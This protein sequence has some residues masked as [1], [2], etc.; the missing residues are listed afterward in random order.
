ML[1][2]KHI[3][4][5][6]QKLYS[7]FNSGV[8]ILDHQCHIIC[9]NNWMVKYSKLKAETVCDHSFEELFP[10]PINHRLHQAIL[11]NLKFGLPAT[12]SNILNKSPIPLYIQGANDNELL[13]QQIYITRLEVHSSDS[14]YC[15]INITDVTAA[16]LREKALENQV[17]ERKKAEQHLL[18]RTHQ[19]QSALSVSNAGVFKFDAIEKKIFLDQKASQIFEFESKYSYQDVFSQWLE[20]V[21][22]TDINWVAIMLNNSSQEPLGFSLDFQFRINIPGREIQWIALKGVIGIDNIS[23]NK[24]IDGV[25]VDITRQ[26]AHQDLLREKEA[27]EIANHAKSAFLANMSHE[28]RTPMHGILSFS[29]LGTNRIDT[30]SHEKLSGYFSRIHESGTRLLYLLNDLL[31]LSKLEAGKMEM[32][33]SR[34]D[35]SVLI[36]QAIEEQ[37]ARMKE[38]MIKT[39]CIFPEEAIMGTFDSVRIIQV[40]TNFLS[41]A[42]KVTPKDGTIIFDLIKHKN[43]FELVIED[44]GI[45]IPE[46]EMDFIFE[47]FQ[48]SSQSQDGS[49]GTGLGLAICKEIIERHYGE[50]GVRNNA[51]GGASFYFKIPISQKTVEE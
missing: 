41:N 12:I 30:A 1:V 22:S 4:V 16:R 31:D 29:K 37:K 17:R 13:Q 3:T 20:K 25:L 45:G 47:K 21:H 32:N 33:F 50:I 15:L 44:N 42:I 26:K 46:S 23:Q 27:A 40:I 8:I 35:L 28:L 24:T 10:E 9:W 39:D 43:T 48:Q 18:K 34:N 5:D 38:L 6:L 49:G 11:T 36:Y 19:L 51:R 7:N 14:A 2:G